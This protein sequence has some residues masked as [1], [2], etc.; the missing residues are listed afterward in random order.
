MGVE[1]FHDFAAKSELNLGKKKFNHHFSVLQG[2]KQTK[3]ALFLQSFIEQGFL[4]KSTPCTKKKVPMQKQK[5][6]K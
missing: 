5:I 3:Y 1:L 4:C 2:T 6:I